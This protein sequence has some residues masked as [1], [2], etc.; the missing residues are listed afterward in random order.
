MKRVVLIAVI[1]L[2]VSLLCAQKDSSFYRHEVKVSVGPSF[3]SAFWLQ[4]EMC[5]ANLSISYFY[6]P[7]K[8]LWVGGNFI[9]LFGDKIYYF[10]REYND[11][12]TYSDFSKSK[13]KYCAIIAPEIRFSYLNRK[14][15][16]AY[17]AL[18]GG[19]GWENGFDN[20]WHKYPKITPYFQVT[21]FGISGNFGKN[22][23]IFFGGEL[24]IGMKGLA[25]IHAG[26]RF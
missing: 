12:G 20:K 14:N 26:Y 8:W 5:Y 7:M 23:N 21:Y 18:S 3:V 9:N 17:F 6:R 24:G 1:L 2:S 13:T 10:I 4:D 19:V 15:I 25:S 22:Y 11:D 16:I